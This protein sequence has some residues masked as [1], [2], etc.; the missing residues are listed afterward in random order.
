M[1]AFWEHFAPQ[2][3]SRNEKK[4]RS[5]FGGVSGV[6]GRLCLSENGGGVAG[7][8]REG[9]N[10]F[11]LGCGIRKGIQEKGPPPLNAWPRGPGPADYLYEI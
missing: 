6:S 4:N 5:D 11:P 9:V 7:K 3:V 10:P 2:N 8:G 1:R